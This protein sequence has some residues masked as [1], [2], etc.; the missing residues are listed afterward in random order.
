[1]SGDDQGE[2]QFDPTEQ[3]REQF[4]KD[5]R[6]ARARDAARAAATMSVVGVLLGSRDGD[7]RSRNG[8][9]PHARRSRRDARGQPR[10]PPRRRRGR[11]SRSRRP[12]VLAATTSANHRRASSQAG[13]RVNL[14]A[15]RIQ[16]RAPRPDRRLQQLVSPSQAIDRGAPQPRC[17]SESWGTSRT[18]PRPSELPDLLMLS[19]DAARRLP[20]PGSSPPSPT[21]VM[22][23]TGALAAIAIVDYAQSRFKLGTRD[24]DDAPGDDGGDPAAGW[25]PQDERSHQGA[26]PRTREEADAPERQKGRRRRHESDAHRGRPPLRRSATRLR[27]SSPR[28]KTTTALRIRA[29]ARKYGIPI[30]ENRPLARALDA[31]VPVGHPIPAAHFAAVARILAFV[32]RS[33]E[34][35][36]PARAVR[37]TAS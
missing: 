20:P 4:R 18:A 9:F 36:A 21:V 10:M 26:R 8:S 13:G 33:G 19:R 31:E 22:G 14:D 12:T 30:L 3:R 27:S 28:G 23:A 32:Y 6:F 7:G 2:R 5:G 34:G 37:S 1:M 15:A 29:E 25:R 35:G 17:G 11:S 24:E 16:A